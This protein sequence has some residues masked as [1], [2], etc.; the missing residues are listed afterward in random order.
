MNDEQ[1]D[2]HRESREAGSAALRSLSV[3][4]FVANSERSVSLTEIMQ[5]VNLPKPTVF[6]IL[7]AEAPPSLQQLHELVE[8]ALRD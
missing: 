1:D 8:L 6:R 7:F 5:A 2:G 4:E 3:M